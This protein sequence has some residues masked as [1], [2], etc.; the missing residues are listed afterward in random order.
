[1][2]RYSEAG[3]LQ[4]G[5]ALC[6]ACAALCLETAQQL[7]AEGG[8]GGADVPLQRLADCA[9]ICETAAGLLERGSLYAAEAM[10]MCA[11]ICESCAEECTQSGVASEELA[12]CIASCK[13]CEA[14][15]R[16]LDSVAV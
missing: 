10:T 2:D 6:R 11:D 3:K 8:A 4:R 9:A 16:E 13:D 5:I 1:M 15:C 7:A 12:R 14:A